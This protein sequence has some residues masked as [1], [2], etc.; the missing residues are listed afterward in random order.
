[1]TASVP[2]AET[3]GQFPNH[4]HKFLFGSAGFDLAKVVARSRAVA[5]QLNDLSTGE[6][7][8]RIVHSG[9][10][11][12]SESDVLLAAASKA[13]V[14]GFNVRPDRKAA[15]DIYN[16]YLG[17]VPID[18]DLIKEHKGDC[19]AALD[20]LLDLITEFTFRRDEETKRPRVNKADS[21]LDREQKKIGEYYYLPQAE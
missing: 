16:I 13:V 9:V 14:V 6:I 15:R 4:R 12:V 8:V 11:A 18:P 3:R 5:K 21:N 17:E 19:T 7:K 10:G 20:E 1:M 2:L